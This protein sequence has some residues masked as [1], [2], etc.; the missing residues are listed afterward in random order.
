M[1]WSKA[2]R[3]QE[4]PDFVRGENGEIVMSNQS[5]YESYING[6]QQE[7]ARE[8]TIESLQ[9]DVSVLKSELSDIKSLLLTLVYSQNNHEQG[10]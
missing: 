8:K 6:V 4:H 1:D 10:N 9:S 7:T 5:V 2:R 3:V